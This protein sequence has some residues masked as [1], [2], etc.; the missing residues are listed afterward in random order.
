VDISPEK[1]A[2]GRNE[3]PSFLPKIST[4][5]EIYQLH[6]KASAASE[7]LCTENNGKFSSP[8]LTLAKNGHLQ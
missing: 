4:A 7:N 6:Y 1:T 5:T 8:C 3:T 2:Y